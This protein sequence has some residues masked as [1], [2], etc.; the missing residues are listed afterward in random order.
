M[1]VM[2]IKLV[3]T[4]CDGVLTD[5][6][7]YYLDSGDEFKKFNVLDGAGFL[8]LHEAGI[9]TAIITTSTNPLIQKRAEKL[10]V[11]DL[12]MGVSDKLSA[13]TLLCQKYGFSL[14]ETAYIGDDLNDLLAIK[15]CGL[16]CTPGNALNYIKKEADYVT[17]RFG[18][19]GC[20]REVVD[21]I[22]K[23]TYNGDKI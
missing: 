7:M 15:A 20:F 8:M 14:S 22:M 19:E 21:I 6:G 17:Q 18:G 16:G 23:N 9:K 5:G 12:I 11:D 1:H 3:A 13:V 2:E 10:L 4:D